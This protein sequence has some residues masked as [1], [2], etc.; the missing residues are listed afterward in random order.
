[1]GITV[2]H[3]FDDDWDFQSGYYEQIKRIIEWNATQFIRVYVADPDA[4]YKR[5]TDFTVRIDGGDIAVR[6]RRAS[7][8]YRDWTIRSYKGGHKTEIHK[9]KEGF[10]RFYLYCW[11]DEQG[12]LSEWVLIDLDRVRKAGLL[13]KTRREIANQDGRTRFIA[14]PVGELDEANCLVVRQLQ[15][16]IV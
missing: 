14:V 6:I 7:Q 1:M 15:K 9:L 12:R 5:A 3:T 10:G 2:P 4:D 13:D 11:E 16:K 8:K